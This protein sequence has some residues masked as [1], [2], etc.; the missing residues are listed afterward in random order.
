[1]NYQLFKDFLDLTGLSYDFSDNPHPE[2]AK[3]CKANTPKS[4]ITTAKTTHQSAAQ[5]PTR[6]APKPSVTES[7]PLPCVNLA[8]DNLTEAQDYYKSLDCDLN[9]TKNEPSLITGPTQTNPPICIVLEAPLPDENTPYTGPA[10]ELLAKMLGAINLDVSVLCRVHLSPWQTPA[11]RP[12]RPKEIRQLS[13]LFKALLNH[14]NPAMVISFGG[15]PAR[16]LTDPSHTFSGLRGRWENIPKTSTPL[17]TTFS[18]EALLRSPIHK[19]TA[20]ADLQA[21]DKRVKNPRD[22]T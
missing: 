18:P 7:T 19:K 2:P 12:L 11:G 9:L 3:P 4:L 16:V 5:Q 8:F 22:L 20:W 17:F 1:M 21:I 14:I 13:A 15:I 10:G 6:N